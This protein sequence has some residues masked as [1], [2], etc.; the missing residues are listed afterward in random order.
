M[1][2]RSHT[3][4]WAYQRLYQ[5]SIFS[6]CTRLYP[7]TRRPVFQAVSRTVAWTYAMT[8]P[9]VR[10]VVRR[11]LQL[12]RKEPVSEAEAVR[13]FVNFGATIADYV[14]VGAMP[15]KK[16][17]SLQENDGGLEH[18]RAAM[19][20]GRGVILATAHFSFF[21]YGAV[22]LGKAGIPLTIGTLPEPTAS[23]TEWRAKWRQRWN[24]ETVPVGADPFSSIQIVRSLDA[25][26]CVALLADRPIAEHG[27]PI[28]LPNGRT[29]F[30]TAPAILAAMTRCPVVP[31][32]VLRLRGGK[33][34]LIAKPPIHVEAA[35]RE[36][37]K[38]AIEDCTRQIAAELFEEI[39][40]HPTQWYQFV[41]VSA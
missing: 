29:L 36:L 30:S 23:L 22:A 38:Q 10:E 32:I 35:S 20:G 26:R 11:N 28:S 13:V 5:D 7:Y 12:L 33:Y 31:V 24:T 19:S 3:E 14:A 41:P 17:Q 37:R 6:L 1:S 4:R 2:G 27:L 16:A 39:I 15:V 21:E 18:L 34:R 9:A 8:Q 25:G 40:Q